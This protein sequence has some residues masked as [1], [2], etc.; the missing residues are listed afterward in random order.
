MKKRQL[1]AVIPFKEK[2]TRLQDI[3]T[4]PSTGCVYVSLYQEL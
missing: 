4:Y 1:E 2:D 3:R